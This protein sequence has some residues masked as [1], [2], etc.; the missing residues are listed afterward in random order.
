[1]DDGG[2][3]VLTAQETLRQVD[4]MLAQRAF[5]EH[6]LWKGLIEG[7]FNRAQ[8]QDFVKQ[9]G[10]IPLH[11]HN[12][13]GPLYIVCPDYRWRARIAEVVYEEGTGR[14]YAGGIPHNE[15]YL[16]F[17][18]EM[19]IPRQQMWDTEYCAEAVAIRNYYSQ[20]CSKNFLEGCSAHMLA[21]EAQ[22]PGWFTKI[23]NKFKEK[24]GIT[25]KGAAFW[26]VHDKA[27][28]D[29]SSVGKEL[30]DQ[31]AKT[32]DDLKLVLRTVRTTLD[33]SRMFDDG[34]YRRVQ[35]LA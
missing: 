25:D 15:L 10:I 8:V 7:T 5:H 23:A 9:H 17:A 30:L 28:E 33:M 22:G 3:P 18:E 21:G 34:L 32:Q 13:H 19:G 2:R 27:D 12:Y 6:P 1:M 16:Q 26:T 20:V 14:I 31:F 11:N 35:A 4:A 29:H 24:F